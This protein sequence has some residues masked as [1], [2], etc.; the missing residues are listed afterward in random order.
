[1]RRS[2]LVA[3]VL[4]AFI[5]G[6]VALW[7]TPELMRAT[8]RGELVFANEHALWL[9][10]A[11]LL[12]AW[13][14]FHLYRRR[15]PAF[16]FSRASELG[17]VAFGPRAVLGSLPRV[18]R[19]VAVVLVVIALARPQGKRR[20]EIEVEGIDI[21]LVMDVSR[22]MEDTDLRLDRLDAAQRTIRTFLRGRKNDRIGLVVFAKEAMLQAPLTLD[23]HALDRIV[24]SIQLGDI[25]AMG[26]AIGDGL[27]LGLASLRRS[28]ARSK[29]AI[30]LTDGDSNTVNEMEPDEA[31]DVAK[32]MGVK[33]FT[34]LMG[35]EAGDGRGFRFGRQSHGVNPALLKRIAGE[36]G[37]RYFNAG[38]DKALEEGFE[39]VRKT[40]EKDKRRMV[41]EVR[42]EL[43]GPLV[44]LAL[45]FLLLEA[46]L[47][48]TWLRRWP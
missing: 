17:Q 34:V 15:V 28:E 4:L 31:K 26:T 22:S 12:L 2:W 45:A 48:L 29:I 5:A 21:M 42:D 13:V 47:S 7:V 40:L 39:E 1:M 19:I 36:T 43:Y 33:V 14:G 38:D 3:Y 25:D 32:K 41:G 24:A 8:T 30:L 11:V 44:S 27:G 20:Q 6:A 9:L 23:Y 10:G 37:G 35:Q 16:S 46:L 18:L